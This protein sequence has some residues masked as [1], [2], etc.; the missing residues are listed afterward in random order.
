MSL[1]I[2]SVTDA[3]ASPDGNWVAVRSNEEAAF[4]RTESLLSG[5]VEHAT[6][7]SLAEY[8]E[9]QGEGITFGAGGAV[10]LAGEGGGKG[11]PGTFLRLECSLPA[12]NP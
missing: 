6:M 10:F 11:A 12:H 2:G 3:E 4:Y 8:T 1:P 9:P 7:V 5:D